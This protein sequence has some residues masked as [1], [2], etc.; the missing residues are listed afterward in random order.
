MEKIIEKTGMSPEQVSRLVLIVGGVCV[1]MGI[2]QE[3]V[4]AII[5]VAYPTFM[6]VC[7]MES[8][9]EE[10]DKQW[11]TYWVIYAFFYIFDMLF[12]TI[13]SAIPIYFL[14]K[15]GVLVYLMHPST[16]GASKLYDELHL[17]EFVNKWF[18][19]IYISS[20]IPK[21]RKSKPP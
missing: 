13:L 20:P 10:D 6:S 5:G 16:M 4:L 19:K 7:A 12:G 18:P 1:A 21:K 11:L 9:E 14:V 3:Y 15:L 17:L 8:K 2:G